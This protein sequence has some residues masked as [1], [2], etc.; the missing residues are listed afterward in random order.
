MLFFELLS[1]PYQKNSLEKRA[2][3]APFLLDEIFVGNRA[4]F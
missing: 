1:L 2:C 4:P 3:V